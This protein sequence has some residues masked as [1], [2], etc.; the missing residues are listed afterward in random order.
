L[1]DHAALMVQ[2]VPEPKK[3][4]PHHYSKAEVATW[5]A[6]QKPPGHGLYYVV[7]DNLLDTNHALFE[8]M[9][10]WLKKIFI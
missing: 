8:E 9:Q 2:T 5:L 6:W 10:Q 7:Y 4:K 3:F 1:F